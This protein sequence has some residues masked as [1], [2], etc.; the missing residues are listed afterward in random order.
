MRPVLVDRQP[1][2]SVLVRL[3]TDQGP[4]SLCL[5]HVDLTFEFYPQCPRVIPSEI[6]WGVIRA[7]ELL[8]LGG[9]VHS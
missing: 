7:S 9:E 8:L 6:F 5:L 1:D 4:C 2:G 3:Q